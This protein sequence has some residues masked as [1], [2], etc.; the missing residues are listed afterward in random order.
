[1]SAAFLSF[2][3][4]YFTTFEPFA[5]VGGTYLCLFRPLQFLQTTTSTRPLYITPVESALLA[6]VG[7]LY[8]FFAVCGAFVLRYSRN[9]H[10]MW[11]RLIS[12]CVLADIGH[13]HAVSIITGWMFLLQPM[14]WNGEEWVNMGML[15][16]GLILRVSWLARSMIAG[17]FEKKS[18]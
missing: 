11:G 5:A 16:F 13:L 2:C 17:S 7:S 12:G 14:E 6:Q 8:L 3:N 10:K 15:W 9:D 18:D 1:M 4:F